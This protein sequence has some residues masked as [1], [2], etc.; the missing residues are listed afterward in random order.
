[1]PQQLLGT[2]TTTL[3]QS[4]VE[5]AG[6]PPEIA[7]PDRSWTLRILNKGGPDNGPVLAID[8]KTAGNLEAP[9]LRVDGDR[10]LLR[11]EECAAGGQYKFYN[12]EY[13]WKLSG[14][15]LTITP[16]TNHCSDR[17][18]LT[19]LTSRPWTKTSATAGG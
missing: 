11:K 4:D 10:L 7:G 5:A 2:Y 14:K 17:V 13:A 9:S 1:V 19:I 16:V 18:A 6:S 15:T 8:N 12:N 3:E